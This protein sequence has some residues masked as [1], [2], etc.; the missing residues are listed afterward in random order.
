[1][2]KTESG[3]TKRRWTSMAARLFLRC[4]VAASAVFAIGALPA[5]AQG[6]KS[7]V[8]WRDNYTNT[9]KATGVTKAYPDHDC[10]IPQAVMATRMKDKAAAQEVWASQKGNVL[11]HTGNVASGKIT[12]VVDFGHIVDTHVYVRNT[13]NTPCAARR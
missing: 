1:M 4:A 8:T 6:P 12:V 11:T 3:A 2:K 13:A 10:N 7:G 5:A 9:V